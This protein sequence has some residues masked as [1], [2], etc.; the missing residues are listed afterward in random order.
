M[1]KAI[2]FDQLHLRAN[3][4]NK[5]NFIIFISKLIKIS[6]FYKF[7]IKITKVYFIY[8]VSNNNIYYSKDTGTWISF[9]KR[10]LESF[11]SPVLSFSIIG[12]RPI[13][14]NDSISE[15]AKRY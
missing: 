7:T 12:R 6:N 11:S 1:P 13:I 10:N 3:L 5:L 8:K 2:E 14:L 4:I 9:H 15:E